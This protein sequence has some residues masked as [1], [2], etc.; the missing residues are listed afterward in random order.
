MNKI[1]KGNQERNS[2]RKFIKIAAAAVY[3]APLVISM[4][5]KASVVSS[6]SNETHETPSQCYEIDGRI[7]CT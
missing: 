5:A 3:V 1:E 6:G 4:E 2:R 7:A